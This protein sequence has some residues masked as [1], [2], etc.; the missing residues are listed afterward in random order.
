MAYG[1]VTVIL[2]KPRKYVII[3]EIEWYCVITFCKHLQYYTV[4]VMSQKLCR[5]SLG[6][7]VD[8]H[9]YRAVIAV[10]KKADDWKESDRSSLDAGSELITEA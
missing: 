1:T 2:T 3:I 8:G 10:L 9:I 5:K 7:L 4:I 6:W